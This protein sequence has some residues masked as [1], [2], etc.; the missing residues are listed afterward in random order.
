MFL[1]RNRINSNSAMA[2]ASRSS[3]RFCAH[4]TADVVRYSLLWLLLLV[5]SLTAMA[6]PPNLDRYAAQRNRLVDLIERDVSA[7]SEYLGTKH[8][9]PAVVRALRAVPREQF[10]PRALH[11]QAY[12]DHPLPIG[13]GQTISQPYIVAVMSHL[14][15]I[16]SGQRIFELGTGSGYQAAVLAEMGAKVYSVE[17]VPELAQRAAETLAGLGYDQVHVRAGDGY[18][19]WPEAA[20]FDAV[21]VTAAHP[22]I[23][24]PLV[25]QL[26]IGG[27]MVMPV[28]EIGGTQQLMVLTKHED[29]RLT[30]RNVLPVRFV[31]ITGSSVR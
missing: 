21:I 16:R 31:P 14:T 15:G 3:F 27:R 2:Y 19:G 9:D 22:D 1:H 30:R 24:Q 25:E 29:N 4:T 5:W 12:R 18:Q 20:P 7:T 26:A 10:V 11:N 28:G 23:P 8:L 13:H 17:I 6:A